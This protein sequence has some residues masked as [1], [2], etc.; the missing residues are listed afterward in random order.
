MQVL[1][2]GQ[3]VRQSQESMCSLNMFVFVIVFVFVFVFVIV[4]F[5]AQ[6]SSFEGAASCRCWLVGKK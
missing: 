2:G 3:K 6:C 4:S 5:F 1:G